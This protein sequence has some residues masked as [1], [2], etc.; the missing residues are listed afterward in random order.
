M[1][2]FP[3]PP[4]PN[5]PNLSEHRKRRSELDT[6]LQRLFTGEMSNEE[7]ERTKDEIRRGEGEIGEFYRRINQ[8]ETNAETMLLSALNELRQA[9]AKEVQETSDPAD[10]LPEPS[11]ANNPNSPGKRYYRTELR[12]KLR[13]LFTGQMSQVEYERTK[14]EI[15]KGEGEIGEFYRRINEHKTNAETLLLS[16]LEAAKKTKAKK[17]RE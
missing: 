9:K 2:D 15:R 14:D 5:T 16:G 17:S 1:E 13:R 3:E 10:R 8:S 11:P 6:K 12:A 7:Y 4:S